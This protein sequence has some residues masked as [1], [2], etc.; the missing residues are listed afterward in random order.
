MT[1]DRH[2]PASTKPATAH[3][4]FFSSPHHLSLSFSTWVL[5]PTRYP[6]RRSELCEFGDGIRRW[7]GPQKRRDGATASPSRLRHSTPTNCHPPTSHELTL[8]AACRP[9]WRSRACCESAPIA[10]RGG[11]GGWHKGR[12]AEAVG[13]GLRERGQRKGHQFHTFVVQREPVWQARGAWRRE[14]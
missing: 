10:V 13:E 3:P 12:A 8:S 14:R 2:L 4:N 11:A 6:I 1:T 7:S 9:T 5:R